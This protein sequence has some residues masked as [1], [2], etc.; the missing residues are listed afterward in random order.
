MS[1]AALR[2]RVGDV[3][4]EHEAVD[5]DGLAVGATAQPADADGISLLLRH[6]PTG[7]AEAFVVSRLDAPSLSFGALPSAVALEPIL[8]RHVAL[9]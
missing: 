3:L 9:D 6:A 8:E 5:V 7:V 2:Q 1:V 4:V